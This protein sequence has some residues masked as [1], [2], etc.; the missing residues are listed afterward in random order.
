MSGQHDRMVSEIGYIDMS[1]KVKSKPF[2]V[3]SGHGPAILGKG[4]AMRDRSKYTRKMKHKSL[5][6][7]DI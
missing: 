1:K 4:G 7:K 3:R 6:N 2:K 5:K